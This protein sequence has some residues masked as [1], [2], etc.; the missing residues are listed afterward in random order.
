MRVAKC[1][2]GLR[3]AGAAVLALGLAWCCASCSPAAGR[4]GHPV[5]VASAGPGR[6]L[7]ASTLPGACC[8]VGAVSPDGTTVFVSGFVEAFRDRRL[9][10]TH[11]ETIAYRAATG[12]RLWASSYQ[13]SGYRRPVAITVSPDGARV[14]V[15]ADTIAPGYGGIVAYNARTGRQL[16]AS[17]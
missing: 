4:R 14:Y 13:P 12:A 9:V 6:Q 15:T 3:V 1:L 8:L 2:R 5:G 17:R 16:W 7:W 10:N 11:F